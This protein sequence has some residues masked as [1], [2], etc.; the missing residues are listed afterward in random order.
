[1]ANFRNDEVAN[2]TNP[3]YKDVDASFVSAAAE[4]QEE[5]KERLD[6]SD[7]NDES[8]GGSNRVLKLHT[9]I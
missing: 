2:K 5:G 4:E 3:S 9:S 6:F 1:M 8:M 7:V